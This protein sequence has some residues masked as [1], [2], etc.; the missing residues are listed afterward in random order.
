MK[1]KAAVVGEEGHPFVIDEIDL[2]DPGSNGGMNATA[3]P[4]RGDR[5][6]SQ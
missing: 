4:D 5:R 2:D 3:T 6:G 1:L